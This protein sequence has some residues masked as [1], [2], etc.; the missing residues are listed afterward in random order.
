MRR[1]VVLSDARR[2]VIVR[3]EQLRQARPRPVDAAFDRA[4]YGIADHGSLFVAEPL[5]RNEEKRLALLDRKLGQ[6]DGHVLQVQMPVLFRRAEQ[7]S[8]QGPVR[9]LHLALPLAVACVE[10]IAEDREQPGLQVGAGLEA[11]DMGQA[12]HDGFLNQIVGAVDIPGERDRE[13]PQ[14]RDHLD[15]RLARFERHP[16]PGARALRRRIRV[17]V[18][19]KAGSSSRACSYRR[20]GEARDVI[21]VRDMIHDA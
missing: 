21:R 7:G 17:E 14:A 18:V 6:R 1:P 2:H 15:H 12:S 4:D 20:A 13:G 9:I 16:G 10:L 8:R 3:L 5:G 19:A 11:L